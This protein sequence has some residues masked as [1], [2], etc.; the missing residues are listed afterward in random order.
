MYL[1]NLLPKELLQKRN[2]QN[3]EIY[4]SDIRLNSLLNNESSD[5]TAFS[6]SVLNLFQVGCALGTDIIGWCYMCYVLI[7]IKFRLCKDFLGEQ[8]FKIFLRLLLILWFFFLG[9][10]E[11]SKKLI[12]VHGEDAISKQ[13]QFNATLLFN[14]LLRSTLCSKRIAEEFHLSSEAFEWLLGEIE[15]RFNLSMVRIMCIEVELGAHI[16]HGKPG[17]FHFLDL[18][19][20][21]K[22]MFC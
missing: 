14:I 19:S 11:L 12:V 22:L 15:T 17:N 21:G 2:L 10:R 5:E 8:H 4:Y 1:I 16:G 6:E 7:M 13:A 3:V 18:E 9:I 20:H